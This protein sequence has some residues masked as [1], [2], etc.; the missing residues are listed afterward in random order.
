MKP[1]FQT[2]ESRAFRGEAEGRTARSTSELVCAP[3]QP[4]NMTALFFIV[5]RQRKAH[6]AADLKL[7]G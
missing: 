5:S 7:K 3:V 6:L 4:P 2:D 1:L